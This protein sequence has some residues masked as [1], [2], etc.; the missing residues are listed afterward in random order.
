VSLRNIIE[1]EAMVRLSGEGRENEFSE[2]E[3]LKKL[4]SGKVVCAFNTSRSK[5]DLCESQASQGYIMRS[6]HKN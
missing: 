6:C 4:R 3:E 5:T 2:M 1:S